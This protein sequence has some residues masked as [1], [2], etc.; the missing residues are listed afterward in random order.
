MKRK[1]KDW[2]VQTAY[3]YKNVQV[4]Y[5]HN[6]LRAEANIYAWFFTIIQNNS[7]RSRVTGKMQ[8][9]V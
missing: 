1:S 3:A 7:I 4:W 6:N 8:S 2:Y 9:N 5:D